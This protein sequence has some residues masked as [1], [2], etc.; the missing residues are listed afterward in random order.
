VYKVTTFRLLNAR[1]VKVI[2]AFIIYI[3]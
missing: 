3:H 2:Q 1:G